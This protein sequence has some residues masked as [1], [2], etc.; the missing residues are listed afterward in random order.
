[1]RSWWAKQG[2]NLRPPVCK[3]GALTAELF[4]PESTVYSLRCRSAA[5]GSLRSP[6]TPLGGSFAHVPEILERRAPHLHPIPAD[7]DRP[8][9]AH[10]CVAYA[11]GDVRSS[12]RTRCAGGH[13]PA[14]WQVHRFH[15]HGRDRR[16][17]GRQAADDDRRVRLCGLPPGCCCHGELRVA[18]GHSDRVGIRAEHVDVR[19]RDRGGGD[20][21]CGASRPGVEHADGH[22]RRRHGA[23]AGDRRIPRRAC[24]R[25][26]ALPDLRGDQR[27]D[28]RPGD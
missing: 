3:T 9:D 5:R 27:R 2:S 15:P 12:P 11:G 25:A 26:G 28:I 4:A 1:M 13:H 22:Q 7:D 20:G 8:G 21:A 18:P 6:I 16:P 24:W 17:V 23:R 19:A 14:G 10:P